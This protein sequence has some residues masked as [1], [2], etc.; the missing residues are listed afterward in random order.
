M[1]NY[2]GID[3]S[4]PGSTVNRDAETGIR[5][6]MIS[7]NSLNGDALNDIYSNG[8]DLGFLSAKE[9]LTA[10]L[11]QAI[12]SAAADHGDLSEDAAERMAGEIID[13]DDFQWA[14]SDESGP[15]LYEDNGLK[16]QTTSHNEL[17]VFKSPFYTKAQFCS[18]CV[19]GAGNLDTFCENG[20]KT[21]CLGTDWFEEGKAP[22]NIWSVETDELVYA[23]PGYIGGEVDGDGLPV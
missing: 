18:P 3:Y 23:M 9:D 7:Q 16:V 2:A 5:Y 10:S 1:T 11:K 15:Y 20:P 17:W 19:P 8:E 12:L 4:G 13:S 14:D 21:Y 22:Y 6:G